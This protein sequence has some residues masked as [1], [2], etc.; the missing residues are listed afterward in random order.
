MLPAPL[1]PAS[2]TAARSTTP[3]VPTSPKRATGI[4]RLGLVDCQRTPLQLLAVEALD[5]RVGVLSAIHLHKPKAARLAGELIH[6]D[7]D[8]GDGSHLAE[9]ILQ[10]GIGRIK[11]EI[12]NK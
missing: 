2:P 12:P 11:R 10:V 3:P 9:Q 8:R 7:V 6:D 4:L 5:G 1:A